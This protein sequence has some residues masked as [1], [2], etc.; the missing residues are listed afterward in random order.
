[1]LPDEQVE[2]EELEI[3]ATE[4]DPEEVVAAEEDGA[5]GAL[6]PR[7]APSEPGCTPG[8]SWPAGLPPPA[9]WSTQGRGPASAL[10][11]SR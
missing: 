5:P 4:E 11:A 2:A 6:G 9:R 3:G 7:A 10:T 1:M 8:L